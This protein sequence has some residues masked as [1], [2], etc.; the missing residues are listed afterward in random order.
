[1]YKRIICYIDLKSTA[2]NRG[3]LLSVCVSLL[4]PVEGSDTGQIERRDEESGNPARNKGGENGVNYDIVMTN[5]IARGR[6][7]SGINIVAMMV[8]IVIQKDRV[9]D[10]KDDGSYPC[11][12]QHYP[13]QMGE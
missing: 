7:S 12:Q 3:G 10:K 6:K 9:D 13:E 11:C 2:S 5:I 4:F 8:H 1:M